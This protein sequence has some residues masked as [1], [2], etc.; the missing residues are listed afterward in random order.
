MSTKLGWRDNSVWMTVMS[1]NFLI[2][3]LLLLCA[4]VYL[5]P[6]LG[7]S[8]E[9]MIYF[10]SVF[11][12]V[13]FVWSLWSWYAL[14]KSLFDPYVMFL[15]AAMLFNGGH[16]FLRILHLDEGGVL[17]GGFISALHGA[18]SS[19]IALKTLF[20]V[21][22]GLVAFHTGGLLSVPAYRR[23][24]LKGKTIAESTPQT[25]YALRLIGWG[26]LAISLVPAC[27]FLKD[28]IALAS[29][30]G[31]FATMAGDR[32]YG[33]AAALE[34][35][36]AFIVPATLFLLAGS[37]DHR[38]NI[39]L[40]TLTMLGYSLALLFV[41][42]RHGA[43]M[44]L[45]AYAWVYHR[46]IRPLP[47]ALLLGAGTLGLFVVMPLVRA[48][49]D[50]VVGEDRF[51]PTALFNAYLSIENP[52]AFL[53]AETGNSMRTVAYT[54]DS[55]PVYRDFDLGESYLYALSTIIPNLFWEVHPALAHGT[56]SQWLFQMAA[57][58]MADEVGGFFGL[59]FSFIAEAYLN[60][61]WY[62]APLAL[63]IMG[64]LLGRLVLWADTSSDPARVAM[65]G[66][67]AAFFLI[68]ARAES[69]QVF[70]DLVW[71]SLI[72]YAGVCGLRLF[73]RPKPYEA[74]DIPAQIRNKHLGSRSPQRR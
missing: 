40:S 14:T 17:E 72:P 33:L 42:A 60:F 26:L 18:F 56:L 4:F 25:A 46:S 9:S 69:H 15:I 55:V 59:G 53:L 5:N 64:F 23:D 28:S 63:G 51:S 61:G 73:M 74:R 43:V 62:G 3:S 10:C 70:R 35:L 36:A 52:I 20:L 16:A 68:Y 27:L 8:V 12:V 38:F 29:T 21:T 24:L 71:Y 34:K 44:S 13:V 6:T 54:V 67:F 19:E 41:G 22:L 31:Y 65:V 45:C 37:K 47:K 66:A 30:S 1:G 49:R 11:L 7:L 58:T 48:F 57:P 2:V 39:T 32:V 50:D